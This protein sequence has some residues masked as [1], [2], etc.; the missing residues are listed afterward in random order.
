MRIYVPLLSSMGKAWLRYPLLRKQGYYLWLLSL[1]I[2]PP[3]D[4]IQI[5]H[6]NTAKWPKVRQFSF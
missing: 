1:L 4:V 2:D 6:E 3:V 5:K